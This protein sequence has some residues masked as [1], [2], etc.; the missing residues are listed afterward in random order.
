MPHAVVVDDEADSADMMAALLATEG[1]TVATAGSLRDARKQLALQELST[2]VLDVWSDVLALPIIG[3]VDSSRSAQIMERLLG[4]IVAK[5][6][7][8][9]IIDVTGVEI[10]DTQTASH[11]LRVAK[12]VELL[13][14][15]C[16][17]TGLRPAV[18][19]TLVQLDVDLREVQTLRSLKH[20]LRHCIGR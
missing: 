16:L 15:R 11:F 5:R 9:V 17:L 4:E 3:T 12:A 6:S 7:R 19:Q 13:G 20:G 8:W 18:A 10:I 2:P 1:F 14:A